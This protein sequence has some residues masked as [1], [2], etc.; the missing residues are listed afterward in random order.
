MGRGVARKELQRTVIAVLSFG[1]FIY[2]L[3]HLLHGDRGYFA[4]QGERLRLSQTQG[5]YKN[6]KAEREQLQRRVTLLRPQSLDI[7]MLDER[8]RAVL[9]YAHPND[10]IISEK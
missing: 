6:I 10:L 9:G 2:F 3:F 8:V 1:I 5:K 7:D 4:L